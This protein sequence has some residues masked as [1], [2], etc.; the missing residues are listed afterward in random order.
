MT[1]FDVKYLENGARCRYT[2]NGR[3]RGSRIMLYQVVSV[4]TTS[5][6]P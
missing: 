3:L 6:D 5:N 1:F 2:Y 4:S